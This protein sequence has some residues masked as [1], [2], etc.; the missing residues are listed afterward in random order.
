[1]ETQ[2]TVNLLNSYKNVYSKFETIK[3]YVIDSEANK[4]S[5]DEPI[6]LLTRSIESS[7][8]DCSDAY[9]LVT[10]NIT[11]TR[12]VAAVGDNSI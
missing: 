7:L 8:C 5:K 11:V 3:W 6:K 4:C 1:M 10:W 9:I 12:T 2:K